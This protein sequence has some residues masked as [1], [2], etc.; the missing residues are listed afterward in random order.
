MRNIR[1]IMSIMAAMLS[2]LLLSCTQEEIA[3]V[4]DPDAENCYGV[5]FPSQSGTG[6]NQIDPDDPRHFTF[7]VSRKKTDDAITVPV[8]IQSETAEIFTVSELY[9]EED[10]STAEIQV[11]FPSAQMGKTYNCTLIIDDPL[12]ASKYASVS[13]HLAFSV[14]RVKWNKV[15]G[16]N[17]ELYG[18][19]RD[20]VFCDWFAVTNPDYEKQ[21][22]IE[23]RDDMPGYYRI[24]DVYDG[25]MLS[26]IFGSDL[27]SLCIAQT[28][29]YINAIDP[30]KVWIPTFKAGVLMTP[31]YG[32]MS[33]GSYVVE[34]KDFDASISSV[35]GKLEEGVITFPT[36]AIQM[37]M[38]NLGWYGA[39]NTG[40]HRIIFPGHRSKDY[41]LS[42]YA[43]ISDSE[44]NLPV[45]VEFGQD[46]ALVKLA[47]F[48]GELTSSAAD[49]KGVL[50]SEGDPSVGKVISLT[51]ESNV[52]YSFD[53]SGEYTVVAAAFDISGNLHTTEYATFGYLT[54]GDDGKN[55]NLSMGLIRS[56]KYASEGLT[57]DNSLEVYI[58]G[59]DIKRLHVGLYEME[60]WQRDSVSIFNKMKKSQMTA[61][62]LDMVNGEGLSLKQG[63]LVPGTEYVLVAEAYNGYREKKY[64][65][66]EWT[67]GQWD[68]RLATYGLEDVNVDLAKPSPEEFTGIY[69]NYA[70]SSNRYSRE[71]LGDVTIDVS[72]NYTDAADAGARYPC[73]TISGLFPNCKKN[74]GLPDDSVEFFYYNGFLYNYKQNFSEYYHEGLYIFPSLLLLGTD[75]G[76]YGAFAGLMGAYVEDGYLAIV[77]SGE[78]SNYG[79]GFEGFLILAFGDELQNNVLGL[80]EMTSDILLVR[81]D[82][83]PDPINDATGK[84]SGNSDTEVTMSQFREFQGL[85]KKGPANSVET[86]EGFLMSTAD[87]ILSAVPE[88]KLDLSTAK[89]SSRNPLEFRGPT[90]NVTVEP[91]IN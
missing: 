32:E 24:F 78:Y 5:F 46:I 74:F 37:K 54:A 64:V 69:H 47:V 83:D 57:S 51:S 8:R 73:V 39:N 86:F 65:V 87:R 59:K 31:E 91:K 49:E 82:L 35:Y 88:S 41:A 84:N 23:E 80:I 79:L 85:V 2:F 28:Y 44:G 34:N 60:E 14:T 18:S 22:T 17:G 19:Y 3:S 77:D 1:Y 9:F 33:I 45:S 15:T 61:S 11:Y 25:T 62:Y 50:I 53:K 72:S 38:E 52:Y 43:G 67:G 29:T 75:G 66:A 68:A 16:P 26:G 10:A 56:D 89:V 48:E 36:G 6:D 13:T 76:A 81:A 4:G 30:D 42:L 71:Y 20:A 40:K 55:V 21:V 7:K 70:I 12:Y 90:F 58:N 63:Y 27:S